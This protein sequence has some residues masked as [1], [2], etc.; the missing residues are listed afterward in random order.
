VLLGGIVRAGN[1]LG[2]A[3]AADRF[4]GYEPPSLPGVL[5]GCSSP[6]AWSRR[7]RVHRPRLPGPEDVA[8][9]GHLVARVVHAPRTIALAARP[10]VS[11]PV[12]ALSRIEND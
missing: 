2:A 3:V 1:R 4:A 12:W 7:V 10:L 11:L 9:V 8:T 6:H 5:R